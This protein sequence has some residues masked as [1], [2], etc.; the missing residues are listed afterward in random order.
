MLLYPISNLNAPF[1]AYGDV[2][3]DILSVINLIFL[4]KYTVPCL[5][6]VI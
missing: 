3:L 1:I 5:Q 6:I 4:L 2:E